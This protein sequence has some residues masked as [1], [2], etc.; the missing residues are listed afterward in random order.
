[1]VDSNVLEAMIK[2]ISLDATQYY[3]AKLPH[4]H[5]T[6]T[7]GFGDCYYDID[8]SQ[9]NAFEKLQYISGLSLMYN[10]YKYGQKIIKS[11]YLFIM[12]KL[13]PTVSINDDNI[14]AFNHDNI[15]RLS[16]IFTSSDEQ[17][18]GMKLI[19]IPSVG[20]EHGSI[21]DDK[22][23]RQWAATRYFFPYESYYF[24]DTMGFNPAIW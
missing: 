6:T 13:T 3:S 23:I 11:N 21:L 5:R 8:I 9:P 1:M 12:K 4:L 24:L 22:F 2:Y 16:T 20:I 17:L 10:E 7:T 15:F 18:G 14:C 19:E